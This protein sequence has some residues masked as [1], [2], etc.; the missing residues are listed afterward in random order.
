[1]H[2]S[3]LRPD[4][5]HQL[6]YQEPLAFPPVHAR[7]TRNTAKPDSSATPRYPDARATSQ[8]NDLKPLKS[9]ALGQPPD[10]PK[11]TVEPRTEVDRIVIDKDRWLAM[12]ELRRQAGL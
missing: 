3:W 6:S 2:G 8:F 9:M 4:V 12:K 5:R 7:D 1:M 11:E 10:P